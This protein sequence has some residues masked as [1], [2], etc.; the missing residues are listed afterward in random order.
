LGRS[1]VA[2]GG[3]EGES[4]VGQRSAL[5]ESGLGKVL[6]FIVSNGG[7]GTGNSEVEV[8]V[9]AIAFKVYII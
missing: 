2:L 6:S 3:E 9:S 4:Y 1:I 5:K 7:P 8:S